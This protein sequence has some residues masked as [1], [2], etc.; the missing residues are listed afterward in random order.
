MNQQPPAIQPP[1]AATR[2]QPGTQ[3]QPTRGQRWPITN[4]KA[5][6]K[7]LAATSEQSAANNQ[8]YQSLTKVE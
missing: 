2:K 6:G 3:Q 1:P 5:L 8:R 4:P 7:R